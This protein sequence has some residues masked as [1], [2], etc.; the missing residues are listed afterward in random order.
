MRWTK[1]R[2]WAIAAAIAALASIPG[3]FTISRIFFVRDLASTFYPHHQW[4]RRTLMQGQ[5][6]FWNPYSGC[7]FSTLTDPVF[8]TFF[9]PVVALR[10]LPERLGFDL[11]V[12]LPVLVAALGAFAFLRRRVTPEA[13]CLGA[14]AFSASGPFLSTA[15]MPNL[16]WSCACLPWAMAG[17]DAVAERGGARC[18]ALLALTFG[19]MLLAGE[20]LTFAGAVALALASALS[21]EKRSSK[22]ALATLFAVGGGVAL[23]AIQLAPAVAAATGSIRS[24]G[25]LGDIWSLHPARLIEAAAPFFFGNFAGMPHELTQWLFGLNDGKGPLILSLYAGVPA[26]MLAALGALSLR[27]RV[28]VFWC[29]AGLLFL[30]AAFGSFT[31]VYPAVKRIVPGLAMLRFPSKFVVFT[32][33]AVSVLAAHGWDAVEASA[34]RVA[35]PLAIGSALA[36]ASIAALLAGQASILAW[37]QKLAT[38]SRLPD[39]AGAAGSF[40]RHLDSGA[41]RILI[42]SLATAI[43]I[44]LARTARGAIARYALLAILAV[45]LVVAG[46]P[47]NPTIEAS[48]L[49]PFDWVKLM[50]THPDDR[51]FAARNFLDEHRPIDDA[52]QLPP[53]PAD[54]PPVAFQATFDVATGSD[55]SA[56]GVRMTLTRELTGLRPREYFQLLEHFGTADRDMRYRFLSWAGT[57]Y[58]LVTA[59]PSMPATKLAELPALRPLALY[60]SQPVAGR[61]RIVTAADIEGDASHQLDRLFDPAFELPA[62]ATNASASIIEDTATRITVRAEAPSGGDLLLLDSFDPGW[63]VTVDGKRAPLVRAHGVFRAVHLDAGKHSVT[64]SYRPRFFLIGAVISALA[65]IALGWVMYPR[66]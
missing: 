23:A 28:A 10:L 6:P 51:L 46:A 3:L 37:G 55:L 26:L 8:Q 66:P 15:S 60:D 39:P 35:A 38:A 7:G 65:A 30:I 1:E 47:I 27:R 34:K 4:F 11:I 62:T 50:R 31:P 14:V 24:A 61:A 17:V 29:A 41:T 12:A 36:L 56:E 63:S 45:D 25:K 58:Y 9:P 2:S 59:P 22:T 42:L 53:Y 13:A 20:P 44:L 43:L 21:Q 33:F 32:A 48:A 54:A 18:T 5:P 40:A 64:F 49:A 57:R 19:L 16:S 52:P